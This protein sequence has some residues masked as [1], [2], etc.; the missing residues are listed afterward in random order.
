MGKKYLPHNLPE[1][2]LELMS[3]G[4]AGVRGAHTVIT[5]AAPFVGSKSELVYAIEVY[6]DGTKFTTLKEGSLSNVASPRLDAGGSGYPAG[7]FITG[8]FTHIVP[9]GTGIVAGFVYKDE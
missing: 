4:G 6:A 1:S 9:E 8:K 3:V 2:A 7:T 5:A